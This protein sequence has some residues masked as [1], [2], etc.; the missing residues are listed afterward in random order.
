VVYHLAKAWVLKKITAYHPK[1]WHGPIFGSL[2][3]ITSTL[4]HAAGPVA[5]MYLFPQRMDRQFF[6]GT[7]AILFLVVNAAKLV[8][9]AGLGMING[10]GLSL[11]FSLA[12]LLP[13]GVWLGF[14]MNRKLNERIFGIIV[15][16]ITF[17]LGLQLATGFNPVVWAGRWLEG[18]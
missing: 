10:K 15:Y 12:F 13:A 2:I 16:A 3:G 18:K 8:P 4:A 6:V 9:Y 5:T 7:N 17:F 1:P 14:W 11:S